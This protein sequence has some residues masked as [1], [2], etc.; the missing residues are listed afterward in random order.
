MPDSAVTSVD[1]SGDGVKATVKTKKGEE[2]LEAEILL[3]AVGVVANTEN[4]GLEEVGIQTD[5]GKIVVNDYCQTNVAGYYAI[6]DVV[7][8]PELANLAS[9][10]GI[11]CVEIIS[12]LYIYLITFRYFT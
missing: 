11:L 10:Q 9:A 6:G 3:S 7:H 12:G 8:G 1:S 4:L 2:V 5:R